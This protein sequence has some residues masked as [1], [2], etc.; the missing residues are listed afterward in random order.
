MK[1][2]EYHPKEMPADF[3]DLLIRKYGR[4]KNF[5]YYLSEEK[6]S[7]L[8]C[9][10]NANVTFQPIAVYDAEKMQAHIS[11]ILDKRLPTREAFFGFLEVSEDANLFNLIWNKLIKRARTAGVT[12]LKGPVNGSIW[13]QYRCIKKSDGSEFFK[14][15]LISEPYYYDFLVSHKP[16]NEMQYYS[17]YREKFEAILVAGETAY[18][19]LETAGFTIKDTQNMNLEELKTVAALSRLVFRNSWGYTELTEKEFMQL[20]SSEKLDTHLSKIYLLY[21]ENNIVGFCGTLKEVDSTLICKTICVLPQ[22]QGIGLGSAL[23]YK[24]HLDAS[25]NNIKKI[26]YALI[27]EGN[28]IKNFPKE[29]AVIFRQYAAFEFRI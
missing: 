27:R 10:D 26:I 17:A 11:L 7:F 25:K 8:F 15:E 18:G 2:R 13:H 6:K 16:V 28:N 20:Y 29:D 9:L 19:K 24:V 4:E 22:Y 21:K 23:A 12:M 3:E 5:G 1:V 14:S